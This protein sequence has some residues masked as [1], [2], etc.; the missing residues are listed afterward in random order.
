MQTG[1]KELD[2]CDQIKECASLRGKTKADWILWAAI[3]L[4]AV[5]TITAFWWAQRK[6]VLQKYRCVHCLALEFDHLM[7]MMESSV[8][9]CERVLEMLLE[10]DNGVGAVPSRVYTSV[11]HPG[12]PLGTKDTSTDDLKSAI[13]TRNL[14]VRALSEGARG[15]K[16]EADLLCKITR[17][18]EERRHVQRLLECVATLTQIDTKASQEDPSYLSR[19]VTRDLGADLLRS[20]RRVLAICCSHLLTRPLIM[21]RLQFWRVFMRTEQRQALEI[22]EKYSSTVIEFPGDSYRVATGCV[23]QPHQRRS[24][25]EIAQA[26]KAFE[27]SI[28]KLPSTGAVEMTVFTNPASIVDAAMSSIKDVRDTCDAQPD[29]T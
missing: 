11:F 13:H 23:Q 16:D 28:P 5:F 4:N 7:H 8:Q 9:Q 15:L 12:P 22:W 1:S 6:E 21:G 2:I 3:V 14:R 10:R 29:Q 27:A 17:S 26:I 25:R 24:A 18:P 19:L 20:G